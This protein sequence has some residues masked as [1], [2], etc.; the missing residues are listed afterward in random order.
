MKPKTGCFH[1]IKVKTLKLFHAPTVTFNI[2]FTAFIQ[3]ES[4]QSCLG[5]V[6]LVHLLDGLCG[7]PV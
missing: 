5:A 4:T 2:Y 6:G 1:L 3:P 7:E